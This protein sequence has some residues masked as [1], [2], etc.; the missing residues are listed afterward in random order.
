MTETSPVLT[1]N[2]PTDLRFGSVGKTLF[3]VEVK[4]ADDGE[5]LAK[6]PNIM[7]GYYKDKKSTEEVFDNE[8]WFKTGDIGHIDNEGF[9]KITDRKKEIFK[10]K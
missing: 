4:I 1:V 3:N 5:I 7:T 10:T 2:S 6:G 9:L 8:G